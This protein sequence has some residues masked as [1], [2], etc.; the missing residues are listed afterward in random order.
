MT[1]IEWVPSPSHSYGPNMDIVK[2]L[3]RPEA[4]LHGSASGTAVALEAWNRLARR[5]ACLT[6]EPDKTRGQHHWR[7]RWILPNTVPTFL[8]HFVPQAII[9]V[10]IVMVILSSEK[11]PTLHRPCSLTGTDIMITTCLAQPDGYSAW[12]TN[13]SG[14]L[15][16][17]DWPLW[18]RN[19]IVFTLKALLLVIRHKMKICSWIHFHLTRSNTQAWVKH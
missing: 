7:H 2:R 1:F 11:S 15:E 5:P 17:R 6:R 13:S 4:D 8:R 12:V 16:R 18:S 19:S 10:S 9:E 14:K 3:S